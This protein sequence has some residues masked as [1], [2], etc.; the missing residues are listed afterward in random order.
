MEMKESW[1]LFHWF[2]GGKESLVVVFS[3][4]L[5][6][7]DVELGLKL[8]TFLKAM[9]KQIVQRLRFLMTKFIIK[10]KM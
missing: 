3:E 8:C 5:R 6:K 10:K 7:A 4:K 2:D 9:L 1:L